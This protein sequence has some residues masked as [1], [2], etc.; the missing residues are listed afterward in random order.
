MNKRKK[1]KKYYIYSVISITLFLFVWWLVTEGL[2]IF[3]QN[4]LAGPVRTFKTLIEKFYDPRPDGHLMQEH[5]WSS[6]D[7]YKRQRDRSPHIAWNYKVCQCT[8]NPL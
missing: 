6:L 5:I 7:V 4:T 2:G 8:L 3:R 1:K